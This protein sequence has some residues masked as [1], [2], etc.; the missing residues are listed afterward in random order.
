MAKVNMPPVKVYWYD[1]G[2]LPV[3]ADLV[4]DDVNLMEDGLGGCIF[5]GTKD[6]MITGCGGF[7]ARLLSGRVPK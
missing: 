3:R 7:N 6:T 1:G 2:L 4:P 5:V